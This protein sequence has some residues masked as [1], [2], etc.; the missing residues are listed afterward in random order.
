[1]GRNKAYDVTLPVTVSDGTLNIEF[2]TDLENAK[3]SAIA[4]MAGQAPA[5]FVITATASAG[6]T[7]SPQGQVSVFS[8]ANQAFAI[9]PN[10][11]YQIVDVKVDG[12]SKGPVAS[13]TFT[14]VTAYHA[15]EAFFAP[16]PSGFTLGINCGG[17]PYTDK[18]GVVYQADTFYSGGGTY[19]TASPIGGTE[20]DALYQTERYGNFIYKIPLPNG[21]YNVT[22]KLAEIYNSGAGGRVFDVKIQ[23]KEVV[24]NLDIFAKA[25]KN[26]AYDLTFPVAVTDGTLNIEFKPDVGNAK[27]SA[28]LVVRQ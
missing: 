6:G 18:T 24:S 9:T 10:S 7:I 26:K 3:I 23:G 16:N 15:I 17:P 21:N 2:R 19:K 4:V 14:N 1:M 25:G 8:G 20:D 27:V 5:Q 13:Y 12:E 11:G 22:L 28:I